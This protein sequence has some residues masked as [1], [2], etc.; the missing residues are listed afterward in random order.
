MT[1][2][3]KRRQIQFYRRPT[4]A[5]PDRDRFASHL[6][7]R[8][9]IFLALFFC[10]SQLVL[11]LVGGRAVGRNQDRKLKDRKCVIPDVA[12][13]SISPKDRQNKFHALK[14]WWI[15]AAVGL[16]A[17]L[18]LCCILFI[19]CIRK[20]SNRTTPERTRET[21]HIDI[22][23]LTAD[24][25][26]NKLLLSGDVKSI[27]FCA[28]KQHMPLHDYKG[29]SVFTIDD[30]YKIDKLRSRT[31]DIEEKDQ[32]SKSVD[33]VVKETFIE[34]MHHPLDKT[35]SDCPDILRNENCLCLNS[36]KES[37]EPC[38]PQSDSPESPRY[39][40]TPSGS[41]GSCLSVYHEKTSIRSL[42]GDADSAAVVKLHPI[43]VLRIDEDSYKY[44]ES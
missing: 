29:H 19:C 18:L 32:D 34:E 2:W 17:L 10:H 35:K 3:R 21:R 31:L 13:P 36:S 26:C 23:N 9:F 39:N 28:E 41:T 14:N 4:K 25:V 11:L 7:F 43:M 30:A 22:S 1:E 42:A 15:P 27:L 40:S 12:T 5:Y 37:G 6:L 44:T 24:E 8:T 38:T 33:G 20:R 16:L